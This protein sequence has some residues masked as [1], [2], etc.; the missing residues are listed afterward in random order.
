MVWKEFHNLFKRFGLEYFQKYYGIYRGFVVSVEDPANTGR[1]QLKVPQ[2]YGDNEYKYWADSKGIYSG[3]GIGSY[4]LPNKGDPV[5][6]SFENGDSRF[7]VWEYGAWSAGQAPRDASPKVKVIQTTSGHRII[8]NDN[9]E[10]IH[11]ERTG[12]ESIVLNSKGISLISGSLSLGSLDG[13]KEKAVLGDTLKEL[14]NELIT[15]IALITVPTALGPSGTPLNLAKLN[16][17]KSKLGTV[18]ST[19][20]TLD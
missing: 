17:I 5:W 2:I 3:N 14:L 11:I 6:V 12:E 1:L 7:P 13:S 15:E 16:V 8:L 4:F 18:L 9:D 10:S 19:K 20:V